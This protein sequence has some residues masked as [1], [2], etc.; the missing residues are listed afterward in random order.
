MMLVNKLANHCSYVRSTISHS[1]Y[2]II[3]CH[4]E[5][6]GDEKIKPRVTQEILLL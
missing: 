2:T 6:L 1:F 3:S 4:H 5:L